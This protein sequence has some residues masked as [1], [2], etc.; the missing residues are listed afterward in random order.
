MTTIQDDRRVDFSDHFVLSSGTVAVDLERGLVLL[1]FYRPTGEY[2]LP[3]GRKNVGETL[4]AAAERETWEESG[5]TCRLF[6]HS[7]PTR[8][9]QPTTTP[10]TEPIAV[11]QRFSQGILKIIFWYLAL[12]DSSDRQAVET[13]EEGEDFEVRWV[14]REDAPSTMSF[15]DDQEIVERA[16]R[17]VPCR[18]RGLPQS[19][20][21]IR[22][23]FLDSSVDAQALG[24]LCIFLGGSLVYGQ[25][26]IENPQEMGDLTDWDGFGIVERK[27]DIV[28]LINVSK[29]KL[30]ALLRIEKEECPQM[31]LPEH[32]QLHMGW[33]VLRFSGWTKQGSKRTIKIWSKT[34]FC[35][36]VSQ[37]FPSYLGVISYKVVRFTR[38]D[39]PT[40]GPRLFIYQPTR[41]TEQLHVLHD[42]DFLAVPEPDS[43][44]STKGHSYKAIS[45][46]VSC[47]LFV[48]SLC[49][50]EHEPGVMASF[51]ARILQKWQLLSGADE[52]E[53]IVPL[54]CRGT[55]FGHSYSHEI[56]TQISEIEA[57]HSE[58][59]R[60]SR[61][62]MQ[63]TLGQ[64]SSLVS[65]KDASGHSMGYRGL[66]LLPLQWRASA[67]CPEIGLFPQGEQ[68]CPTVCG[69][70]NEDTVLAISHFSSNSTGSYAEILT[71][72]RLD[73]QKVYIKSAD[74]VPDELAALPLVQYYFPREN[75]QVL[76]AAQPDLQR[77]FFQ[78]FIGET[79]NDTRLRYHYDKGSANGDATEK[80]CFSDEW[81]INLELCR[82]RDALAVY[83]RSFGRAHLSNACPQQ[84]IHKFFHHRL[85]GNRRL[86]QFYGEGFPQFFAQTDHGTMSLEAF[87]DL[88][89][90]INGRRYQNLRHHLNRALVVLDP[91]RIGGLNSLP[92]AFGMGDGHGG[93]V[94]IS[95]EQGAPS[96][97][98]VDY[99]VAGTHTPF[100][101]LAKPIYQDGFFSVAYADL[102]H[103]D[104]THTSER[105]GVGIKWR[106]EEGTIFVDY[107]L[108]LQTL[109]K[110]VAVI[111]LEYL[112]RPMLEELEKIASS[113][114]ETPEETLAY[115]LFSCA[116][117]TRDYSMRPD[118]FFLNLAVGIRLATEIRKVFLD[119]FDWYNWAPC[120]SDTQGALQPAIGGVTSKTWHQES[121]NTSTS[122]DLS[123][124]T[125][126]Y[127]RPH[128]ITTLVD[129]IA[130]PWG[131]KNG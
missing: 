109:S 5:Y 113:L 68:L 126:S 41:A 80:T 119:L 27:E 74:S 64:Q 45:P 22:D 131:A 89:M 125:H 58:D 59:A 48:T 7:L 35:Q 36:V 39:H 15:V 25:L 21:P 26:D 61:T 110:G 111:K 52:L 19:I 100:L 130:S 77:I 120:H 63:G 8:A 94:M 112:L 51:K 107:D 78:R 82:A 116:L 2:L 30:C 86:R 69:I 91:N 54:F 29:S 81:F 33:D 28:R 121:Q 13:Q 72:D 95:K 18:L 16:L 34:S 24:F 128:S 101:D 79:L 38:R 122:L 98:Y 4:E 9:P 31:K 127:T 87:S 60:R 83:L 44:S 62:S 66:Y 17:A 23:W 12:V 53:S 108:A 105:D 102:L 14:R 56:R 65:A 73:W 124:S 96:I 70:Q 90:V 114:R 106:V 50:F 97:L 42:F 37:P 85:V 99:E 57:R 3:K 46:G 49:V 129:L 71:S 93:N 84:R 55:S 76:A 1:L 20:S 88:P 47:D 10:H 104:L 67:F 43:I 103:D 115:S 118:V 40:L 32:S 75:V 123:C 11:Q 92:T 6:R 117:L